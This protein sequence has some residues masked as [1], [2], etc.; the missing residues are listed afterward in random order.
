MDNAW[1]VGGGGSNRRNDTTVY[2]WSITLT[3]SELANLCDQNDGE[4][5]RDCGLP[6]IVDSSS[7]VARI[8]CSKCGLEFR[9]IGSDW[10]IETWGERGIRMKGAIHEG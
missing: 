10:K 4:E 7:G 5:I 2:L 9:H 3:F 8:Y 6:L 1:I